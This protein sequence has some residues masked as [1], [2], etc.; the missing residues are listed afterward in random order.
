M[1]ARSNPGEDLPMEPNNRLGFNVANSLILIGI[2]IIMLVTNW[3]LALLAEQVR[4]PVEWVRCVERMAADGVD[5]M[6]E[7]GAGSA[8]VGMVRRLAPAVRRATGSD[9]VKPWNPAWTR[10]R[11]M[12]RRITRPMIRAKITTR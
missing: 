6:I 12:E 8:L 7:C 2:I 5:T 11:A 3:Q 1:I 10:K 9:A 4:S